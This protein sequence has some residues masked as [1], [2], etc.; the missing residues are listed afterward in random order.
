MTF[1]SS[2]VSS[3][4]AIVVLAADGIVIDLLELF[5]DNAQG[6]LGR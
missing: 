1:S 5:K 4:T 3:E 2:G 6:K